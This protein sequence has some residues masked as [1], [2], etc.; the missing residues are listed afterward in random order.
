LIKS[1]RTNKNEIVSAGSCK[2]ATVTKL[3]ASDSRP[4]HIAHP[5]NFVSIYRDSNSSP[6][7]IAHPDDFE[8][9]Y[10]DSIADIDSISFNTA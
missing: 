6:R 5:D 8:S 10:T 9:G 4:H 7:H 3:T 2:P 1:K